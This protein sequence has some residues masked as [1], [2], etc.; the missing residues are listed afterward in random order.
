MHPRPTE[1]D[2]GPPVLLTRHR[3]V[4][5]VLGDP[6]RFT[7]GR[8][9]LDLG[10]KRPV[11]PL[12]ADPVE[13]GGLRTVLDPVFAPSAI[14]EH[15]SSLRAHA[16]RLIDAFPREDAIEAN[17]AFSRL[18]PLLALIELLDLPVGDLTLLGRLHDG[19]L[20]PGASDAPGGRTPAGARIYAYLEPHVAA[21]RDESGTDLIRALHQAR[22]DGHP[23]TD[24]DIVDTCYLLLLAGIDPVAGALAS[25]LAHF[26]ANPVDRAA[27]V[28]DPIR[29]RRTIEEL[30]RWGSSVEVLTRLAVTETAVGGQLVG[31]G[32][33]VVCSVH[34]ANRDAEV[35]T[36]PARFDP[37]RASALHLAFGT[38]IH[39]CV[40]T[41]LARLQ[42]R[43]AAEELERR[44]PGYRLADPSSVSAA[45]IG[46]RD[47]LWIE[48]TGLSPA[49]GTSAS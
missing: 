31:E 34:E 22:R 33:R 35:F 14:A 6:D 21:R 49:L 26:G 16:G 8:G 17:G 2:V 12:Q 18:L 38:G 25:L 10:Q 45:T 32:T 4:K 43:I 20:G 47:E 41:H 11:L 37:D 27:V 40:G 48:V 44:L 15:E 46:A 28:A 7:A 1:P 24:E 30:L 13:H 42:L 9:A 5:M 23:V 3:D 19:I 29:L 39:R 36:D